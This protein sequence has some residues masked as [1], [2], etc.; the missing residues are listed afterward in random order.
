MAKQIKNKWSDVKKI[1]S[2]KDKPELLKLVGD[3]FSLSPENK[4]FINAR[5]SIV[6]ALEPYKEIIRE[7]VCPDLMDREELRLSKGRKAI[8]DYRKAVGDSKGILELTVYYVECGNQLTLDYGDINEQFY[9]SIESMFLNAI[10]ILRKSSNSIIEQYLPRLEDVVNKTKGMG[11][12]Y[13]DTLSQYLD[14]FM[15]SQEDE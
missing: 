8:S 13:H 6:N 12:G 10:K 5:Y 15:L 4:T 3:L 1:L 11:W 2:S 7:S 9:L 14:E